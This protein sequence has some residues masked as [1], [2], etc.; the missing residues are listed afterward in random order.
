[1][2]SIWSIIISRFPTRYTRSSMPLF[3][4]KSIVVLALNAHSGKIAPSKVSGE[5]KQDAVGWLAR[6]LVRLQIGHAKKASRWL[7]RVS[8]CSSSA[9]ERR[10]RHH[11]ESTPTHTRAHHAHAR[12]Q[13]HVETVLFTRTPNRPVHRSHLYTSAIMGVGAY[14]PHASTLC[15]GLIMC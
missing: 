5:Q 10:T 14:C 12:T 1:M 7:A 4:I 13:V 9:P 2:I 3:L 15:N 6:C 11:V 8:T